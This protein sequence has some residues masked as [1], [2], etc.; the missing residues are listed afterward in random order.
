M[1][2]RKN[3]LLAVFALICAC[4]DSAMDSQ[5]RSPESNRYG[6]LMKS[7][8]SSKFDVF[9]IEDED[10]AIR[11]SLTLLSSEASKVD[12][13]RETINALLEIKAM[14]DNNQRLA[15]WSYAADQ[16]TVLGMAYYSPLTEEYHYKSAGELN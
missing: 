6:S 3:T 1:W 14:L 11:I 9:R 5:D 8:Q 15:V 7:I 2:I 16:K 4:S 13:R 12:T 10:G